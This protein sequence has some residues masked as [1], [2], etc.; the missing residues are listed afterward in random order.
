[1][2]NQIKPGAMSAMLTP[3]SEDGSVKESA[4]AEIVDF[5]I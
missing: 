1:M 4:I 2:K 3:F 5:Q